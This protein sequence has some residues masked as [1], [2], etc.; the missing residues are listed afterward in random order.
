VRAIRRA[1]FIFAAAVLL[2]AAALFL[3]VRECLVVRAGSG[4]T[5]ALFPLGREEPAFVI[6]WRH[7]V[8]REAC[9]EYYR[10]GDGGTIELYRTVFKGL[11]AGLPFDDEGGT[12]SLQDGSIVIDGLNR[13]FPRIVL[14]ALP[15]T[16]HRLTV[17]GREHD[18]LGL[19]GGE[20]RAAFTIEGKSLGRLLLA[21]AGLR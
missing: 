21:R 12:V 4:R 17:G 5:A 3:P 19:L 14:V 9:A 10:R 18:F 20:H 11:G 13:A 7:S 6:S 2:A 8:T 15:L 1:G 16:E